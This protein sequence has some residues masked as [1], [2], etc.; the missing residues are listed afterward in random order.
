MTYI[1]MTFGNFQSNERPSFGGRGERGRGERGR[2]RQ[3]EGGREGGREGETEGGRERE[4]DRE[5]GSI[6]NSLI[7]HM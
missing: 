4:G 1:I 7:K 2:G 5:D 6:T 3:R